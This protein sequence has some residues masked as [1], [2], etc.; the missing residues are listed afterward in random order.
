MYEAMK[1]KINS[2]D[3]VQ[4]YKYDD[5][6]NI[7]FMLFYKRIGFVPFLYFLEF[8]YSYI[9]YFNHINQKEEA[10]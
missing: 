6:N 4:G 8:K 9:L 1:Q 3:S 10:L 5:S 7:I 2:L